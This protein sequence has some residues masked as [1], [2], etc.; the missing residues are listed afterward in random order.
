MKITIPP[1]IDSLIKGIGN[2]TKQE[3]A[4]KVYAA[5]WLQR[6]RC[7]KAGFFDVPSK[8]LIK[9]NGRYKTI[10]KYFIDNKVL[11]YKVNKKLITKEQPDLFDL[12]YLKITKAYNK[13]LGICM[14]YRFKV[15]VNVNVGLIF[16]YTP[17]KELHRWYQITYDS[18]IKIGYSPNTIKIF[19]DNF[20]RRLYH[21]IT[22]T[23]KD[24]SALSGCVII[25]A[26]TSQP[27]LLYDLL[28]EKL[29]V[30][31]NYNYI[32][33]NGFNFYDYIKEH[34]QIET[35]KDAFIEWLNGKGNSTYDYK[36]N[37]FFPDVDKFIQYIKKD[38]YKNMSKLMQRIESKIWI[39]DIL[40]N[41]P[42]QFALTIHDSIIIE[43]RAQKKILKYIGGKYPSMKL[44]IKKYQG[45]QK[46]K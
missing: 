41:I 26:E 14:K 36:L 12:D 33:D 29:I 6:N 5:I 46:Y 19:R 22:S 11:E 4:Y 40:E 18:L 8:Y 45:G 23:Y 31:V 13:S 21:N 10:I 2:K 30:D 9:V 28:K 25:D 34:L 43:G 7:N 1:Q 3:S 15:N 32:F 44:H 42:E 37:N 35:P 38:D 20:G 17:A 24:E 27:R 39:D 16:D